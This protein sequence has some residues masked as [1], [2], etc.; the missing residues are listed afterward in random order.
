MNLQLSNFLAP[1]LH[2][3]QFAFCVGHTTTDLLTLMSQ[4]WTDALA[5]GGE[6]RAVALD[7]SK[8]FDR[9]WHAKLLHKLEE[10]EYP[11]PFSH[12]SLQLS[13]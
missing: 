12:G 6:A 10:L 2:L 9:V 1:K 5:A 8:A 13:V 3:H 4:S 11:A 7:I